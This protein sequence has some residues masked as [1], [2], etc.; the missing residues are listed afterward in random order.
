MTTATMT[1]AKKDEKE[2]KKRKSH[3]E[4]LAAVTK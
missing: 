2:K 1:I 4:S 3:G